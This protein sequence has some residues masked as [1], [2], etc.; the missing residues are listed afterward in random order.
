MQ[1][2][3]AGTL[4]LQEIIHGGNPSASQHG[5]ENGEL[6]QFTGGNPHLV[7]LLGKKYRTRIVEKSKPAITLDCHNPAHVKT[8]QVA[9]GGPI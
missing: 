4:T 2:N 3:K 5:G 1:K 9:A 7:T 6:L 8:E